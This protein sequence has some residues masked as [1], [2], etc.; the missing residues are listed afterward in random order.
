MADTDKQPGVTIN[1]KNLLN[2]SLLAIAGAV[3]GGGIS[4]ASAPRE[5]LSS[6]KNS[7]DVVALTLQE[8]KSDLKHAS[9]DRTRLQEQIKDIETRLRQREQCGCRLP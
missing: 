8:I 7:V 2:A 1:A 6:L 5:E 9:S 3:G 4:L